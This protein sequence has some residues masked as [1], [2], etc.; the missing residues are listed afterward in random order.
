MNEDLEKTPGLKNPETHVLTHNRF[1]TYMVLIFSDLKKA[2]IYKMTYRDSPHQEI[3]IVTKFDYLHLFEPNELDEKTHAMIQTNKTFLF[4]IGGKKYFYVGERIFSFQTNDEITEYFSEDGYNDVKY[5]FAL[6]NENI[7][8]LLYQKYIPVEEYQNTIEQ[9][10]YQHLY[11]KNEEITNDPE[12]VDIVYGEDFL[13][14]KII[15]SKH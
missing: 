2:Q 9:S 14:C 13:N 5:P 10:E 15:H 12:G 6:S 7:Y 1:N 4:K 8:Y 11:K 3:E